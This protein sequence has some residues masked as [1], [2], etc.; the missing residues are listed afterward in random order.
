MGPFIMSFVPQSDLCNR[1]GICRKTPANL[2]GLGFQ[3][4]INERHLFGDLQTSLKIP[5]ESWISDNI[6][7]DMKDDILVRVTAAS[8][9]APSSFP[10]TEL[11]PD[12]LK[13]GQVPL[14]GFQFYH[15]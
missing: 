11:P 13:P 5:S 4:H 3:K 6:Q 12:S 8:R 2:F 15:L 1:E 10:L 7:A 9:F 14:P